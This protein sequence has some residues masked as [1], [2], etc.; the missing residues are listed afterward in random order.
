M[1]N[2]VRRAGVHSPPL[3]KGAT[4]FWQMWRGATRFWR[5]RA[6]GQNRLAPLLG[7]LFGL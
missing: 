5:T 7:P 1:L 2:S 6:G 3:W 4:R